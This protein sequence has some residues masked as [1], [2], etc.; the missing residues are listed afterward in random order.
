MTQQY[1]RTEAD[2]SNILF[3][4]QR[5]QAILSQYNCKMYMT[6]VRW[7]DLFTYE[8]FLPGDQYY[9]TQEKIEALAVF[10]LEKG[11]TLVQME[12][13]YAM[14]LKGHYIGLL[15]SVEPTETD[16][17]LLEEQLKQEILK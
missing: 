6:F 13:R 14:E 7:G 9:L 12:I 4:T 17:V 3:S 1:K 2:H 10:I 16:V 15:W 11:I 5:E 8:F